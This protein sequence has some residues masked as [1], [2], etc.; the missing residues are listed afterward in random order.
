M[1]VVARRRDLAHPG[2]GWGGAADGAG[3]GAARGPAH[4][5]HHRSVHVR[6][7][8]KKWKKMEKN[9]SIDYWAKT[10]KTP[11]KIGVTRLWPHWWSPAG[12]G[13]SQYKRL[14]HILSS[15]MPT[16]SS[17]AYMSGM[18]CDLTLGVQVWAWCATSARSGG[19]TARSGGWA[20]RQGT[21]SGGGRAGAPTSG[22][23][24]PSLQSVN[25]LCKISGVLIVITVW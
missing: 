8:G 18:R 20:R 11:R 25:K 12:G 24:P 22:G 4:A 19:R 5:H 13:M 3:G 7:S 10:K 23:T 6:H 9:S 15:S 16:L 21:S 17:I 1:N 2:G 14:L